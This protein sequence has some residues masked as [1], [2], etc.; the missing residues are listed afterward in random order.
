MI[1]K[2]L[3][4]RG[5][6]YQRTLKF[7]D[8]LNIIRGEKTSGKSLVLSL[9][10]YCLGKSGNIN[11]KVQTELDEHIEF[12]FLEVEIGKEVVTICR[13][14]KKE[15]SVFWVYNTDYENIEEYIPEKLNKKSLQNFL[16]TKLGAI[17]FTKTKNKP[18]SNELT[19]E[20]ISFR[21]IYRYCFVNQ[22]E[23]GTRTFLSNNEPMKKYKNPIAFEMM[24]DLID[25]SQNN[26]Q[27]EIVTSKNKI[28][29][30]KKNKENLEGYLEQRDNSDFIILLNKIDEL[31]SEIEKLEKKKS[32]IL[33]EKN[34]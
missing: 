4:V 1:I 18:R 19:T 28:E 32:E 9:I 24:F 26:L 2:K 30:Y 22:H 21:D 33:Q 13:G 5:N 15:L 29:D 3:I 11:L 25:Y 7:T 14:I 31:T 10:D 17:E 12:I 34:N 8:G 20:T 6:S 27:T 16:M 23:L